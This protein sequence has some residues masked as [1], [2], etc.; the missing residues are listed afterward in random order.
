MGQRPMDPTSMQ[1]ESGVDS[2]K[3][4]RFKSR[5]HP[6]LQSAVDGPHE[7]IDP[8]FPV[9]KVHAGFGDEAP[10]VPPRLTSNSNPGVYKFNDD[11]DDD[12]PG[13]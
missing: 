10:P 12:C 8:R 5:I 1:E 13:M 4:D 7:K 6:D 11:G 2:A 9:S 3:A